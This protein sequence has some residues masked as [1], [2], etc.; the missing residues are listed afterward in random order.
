MYP[1]TNRK[2]IPYVMG[3]CQKNVRKQKRDPLPYD[4]ESLE[5]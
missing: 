1:Y 5:D 2:E 4:S 3:T